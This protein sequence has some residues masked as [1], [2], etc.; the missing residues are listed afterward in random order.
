MR[1]PSQLFPDSVAPICSPFMRTTRCTGLSAESV[2]MISRRYGVRLVR[3]FPGSADPFPL[4]TRCRSAHSLTLREGS[5]FHPLHAGRIQAS[6]EV[7][8]IGPPKRDWLRQLLAD[9]P[10]LLRQHAVDFGHVTEPG[11]YG[12]DTIRDGEEEI[13]S[14]A[15]G[16]ESSDPNLVDRDELPGFDLQLQLFEP[17][18]VGLTGSP[19]LRKG[20]RLG[21]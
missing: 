20:Q 8:F 21:E 13:A 6:R 18:L 4:R 11:D 15:V 10:E 3:H 12:G 1:Y 9:S 19:G 16:I 2:S 5:G 7:G 14:T 17:C